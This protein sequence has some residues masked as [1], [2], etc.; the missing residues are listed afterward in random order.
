MLLR[1]KTLTLLTIFLA[2]CAS[3]ES[4]KVL[5]HGKWEF[6]KHN[7]KTKACLDQEAVIELKKIIWELEKDE[8]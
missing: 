5:S 3:K 6:I 4:C 1:L 8:Q 2:S 7:N